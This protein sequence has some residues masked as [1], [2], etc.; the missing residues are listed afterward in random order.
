[1]KTEIKSYEDALKVLNKENEAWVDN[2]PKHIKA[3]YKLETICEALNIGHTGKNRI[4]F[5]FWW[6]KRSLLGGSAA[7]GAEGGLGC[8]DSYVRFS[9]ADA[10]VGSRLCCFDKETAIYLGSK[11]FAKLWQDYLL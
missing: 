4:Y 8:V 5:P 11:L 10:Y 2:A 1:M 7:D 6:N 3:Q 9:G